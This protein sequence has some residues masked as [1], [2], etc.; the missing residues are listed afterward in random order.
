MKISNLSIDVEQ[1]KGGLVVDP[2]GVAFRIICFY[3]DFQGFSN[4]SEKDLNIFVQVEVEKDKFNLDLAKQTGAEFT[5]GIDWNTIS[6]KNSGYTVSFQ[7]D[8][9]QNLEFEKLLRELPFE[10]E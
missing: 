10:D 3:I 1:L 9:K 5:A 4:K 6:K 2:N 7:N 8:S